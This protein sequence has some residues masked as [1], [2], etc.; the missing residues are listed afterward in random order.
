MEP[1]V[2][3]DSLPQESRSRLACD[4]EQS[5]G[6]RLVVICFDQVT[7]IV[8][9][10]PHRDFGPSALQTIRHRGA[11]G[12]SDLHGALSRVARQLTAHRSTR[13]VLLADVVSTIG[14]VKLAPPCATIR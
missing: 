9:D 8:H 2:S 5:G 11:L 1:P 4:A 14:W 7:Q 3:D 12:A 6:R 10:G 13:L